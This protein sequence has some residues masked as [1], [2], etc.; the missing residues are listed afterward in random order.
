VAQSVKKLLCTDINEAS[1]ADNA[2]RLSFVANLNF[3]YVDFRTESLPGEFGAAYA[4]D[5][6]EHIF[7]AEEEA[8]LGNIARSLSAHGVAL[9]GTPNVTSE[10][11]ASEYSRLGHVNLQSSGGMQKSLRRFFNN[12]FMF[13]MN[14]EVVHTGY[15]PM[16]HYL[17]ALCVDPIGRVS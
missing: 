1:L 12:V 6:L 15:A 17:W 7:P 5:V 3:R 11:Y 2:D 14:D 8:F 16:A 9:F 13:A 10:Q 4:I